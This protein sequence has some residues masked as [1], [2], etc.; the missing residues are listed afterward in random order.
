MFQ[1][2]VERLFYIAIEV[3]WPVKLIRYICWRGAGFREGY[4]L[5]CDKSGAFAL[6]SWHTPDLPV[7]S[8]FT[9]SVGQV[10]VV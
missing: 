5:L 2:H 8:E 3:E 7:I 6:L 9:E 1:F 10:G 4:R